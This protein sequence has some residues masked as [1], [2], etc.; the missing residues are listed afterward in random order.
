MEWTIMKMLTVENV[1]KTYG[2]KQLF[3]DISFNVG[4]KERIGLIG[5]NGTGKSS[6]LRIV[7]GIDIP[8]QGEVISGKDYTISF[9]SQQPEF[10]TDRT[11]LDQVFH[12]EAPIL[13]LM[14]EY[15]NTLFQLEHSPSDHSL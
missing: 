7:A 4:E 13:K 9:L 6:L 5:V 11:V 10:D 3:T 14:R 12:G 1:T 8:D 2:E 15:E